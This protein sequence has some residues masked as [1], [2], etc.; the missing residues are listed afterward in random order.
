MILRNILKL[1]SRGFAPRLASI[2]DI[3][4]FIL[5]SRGG[6]RVGTRWAQRFVARRPELKTRFNRVYDFQR[7]LCED[8]KLI[9]AWFRLI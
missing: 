1:D 4:N 5:E 9:G 8:P 3:A 2:K 6:T 7:A